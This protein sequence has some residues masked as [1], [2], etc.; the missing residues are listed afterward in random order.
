MARFFKRS[1]RT[2]PAYGHDCPTCSAR[3]GDLCL[4][5]SGKR[6]SLHPLRRQ[7]AV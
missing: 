1:G 6:R 2:D 3:Q 4:T 5:V 7:L